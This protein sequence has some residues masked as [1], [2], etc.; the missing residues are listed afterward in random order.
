MNLPC[1]AA[2]QPQRHSSP[3]LPAL[4]TSL[5][6]PRSLKPWRSPPNAKNPFSPTTVNISKCS[7]Y[8]IKSI[9]EAAHLS[10]TPGAK[11][12]IPRDV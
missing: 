2:A 7:C 5:P 6:R 4:Q 9:V 3:P 10:L 11:L 8:T 1:T 12:P